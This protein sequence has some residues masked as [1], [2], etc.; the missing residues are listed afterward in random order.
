MNSVSLTKSLPTTLAR[1]LIVLLAG[2]VS[3]IQGVFCIKKQ[4]VQNRYKPRFGI[5]RLAMY[6][7]TV[8][9]ILAITN[10]FTLNQAEAHHAFISMKWD[11]EYTGSEQDHHE[12]TL[13]LRNNSTNHTRFG[14]DVRMLREDLDA[15]SAQVKWYIDDVLQGQSPLYQQATELEIPSHFGTWKID[16]PVPAGT[17][18]S[19]GYQAYD[20]QDHGFEP[21]DAAINNLPPG[22]RAKVVLDLQLTRNHMNI[23]NHFDATLFIEHNT[24]ATWNDNSNRVIAT[25]ASS[26]ADKEA[27]IKT[28]HT[29]TSELSF[30]SKF[31][32]GT[33][34]VDSNPL[35]PLSPAVTVGSKTYQWGYTDTSGG[36]KWL[37][38]NETTCDSVKCLDVLFQPGSLT[39]KTGKVRAELEVKI[40]NNNNV[41]ETDTLVYAINV[42]TFSI[43]STHSGPIN[44]NGTATFEITT[45]TNLGN[46]RIPIKIVPYNSLNTVGNIRYTGTY[47]DTGPGASGTIRNVTLPAFTG[48]SP[49]TARFDVSTRGRDG[50]NTPQGKITVDLNHVTASG[51]NLNYAI[52]SS[53]SSASVL[54]NDDNKPTIT[55]GN[56]P[57]IN[58]GETAMF[59][60]EASV[61]PYD[62][63][64]IRY[65]PTNTGGSFLPAGVHNEIQSASVKFTPDP[66]DGNKI[67]GTLPV[68]TVSAQNAT[69]AFS[70]ALEADS[71]TVDPKYNKG[72]GTG[73]VSLTGCLNVA[74]SL[75]DDTDEV[76]EG[77]SKNI[78]VTADNNP[79]CPVKFRYSV[80]HT[81]GTN[82]LP[83]S[84]IVTNEVVTRTFDN[85]TVPGSWTASIAIN[86]NTAN[87][88]DEAHGEFKVTLVAADSNDAEQRYTLD[89]S[90]NA[91]WGFVDV[92]VYDSIKPLI[93]IGTE[94]PITIHETVSSN[95]LQFREEIELT[96][97]SQPHA[98]LTVKFT[99]TETSTNTNFLKTPAPT[100]DT[101]T[102]A[103]ADPPRTPQVIV[104]KIDAI[105][106][107]D[108]VG[109]ENATIL[110]TLQDDTNNYTLGTGAE[111]SKS[112]TI[113]DPSY[114]NINSY[115][116]PNN[117]PGRFVPDPGNMHQ[118]NND[119]KEA[120]LYILDPTVNHRVN[121]STWVLEH[122]NNKL[123]VSANWYL[124]G[125]NMAEGTADSESNVG[126]GTFDT[127][128]GRWILPGGNWDDRY[129][130]HTY[131]DDS[132]FEMTSSELS[133]IPL[134][135][136]LELN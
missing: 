104:G 126:E 124:N 2:F 110:L 33:T 91:N 98:D 56:A 130:P 45:Y 73:T 72:S 100:Q 87:S 92:T 114:F 80:A 120:V 26:A 30:T 47:L 77:G 109:K 55:I 135:R 121:N 75:R 115:R 50:V 127:T 24:A 14:G 46:D 4:K 76:T 23:G 31:Y 20:S 111:K 10:V 65:R 17:N 128:I 95:I 81:S 42:P 112:I 103:P 134:I 3:L 79:N 5:A 40:T 62:D 74:L 60:L 131:K 107:V 38:G 6:G 16:L 34:D 117:A 51:T 1:E 35:A 27:T 136:E 129:A 11:D 54:V 59:P 39:S 123:S 25:A 52:D 83:S 28:H 19:S 82:F 8:L 70:V 41:V 13:L 119:A 113:P 68:P 53:N 12:K 43:S 7:L 102:F 84:E 85:T 125:S 89:T 32:D 9:S 64:I 88:N 94:E 93:K 48:N 122:E 67:K 116:L 97:D 90:S 99:V 96:S 78:R 108:V 58:G 132:R 37:V 71:D 21:N 133:A 18:N 101:I 22:S 105:K 44:E 49:Y 63:L 15:W 106:F 29:P 86:T 36:W 66:S 118:V 61:A 69:G 57:G